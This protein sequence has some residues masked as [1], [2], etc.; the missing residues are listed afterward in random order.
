VTRQTERH[1]DKQTDM[2]E[3]IAVFRKFVKEPKG[4]TLNLLLHYCQIFFLQH[5]VRGMHN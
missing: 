3:I 2:A 4:M 1:R 5:F